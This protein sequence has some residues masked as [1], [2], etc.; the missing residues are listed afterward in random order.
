MVL[1]LL[2][3]SFLVETKWL[4]NNRLGL[5]FNLQNV[6]NGWNKSRDTLKVH[7]IL[8]PNAQPWL[9]SLF[10]ILT[11]IDPMIVGMAGFTFEKD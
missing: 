3:P 10:T 1:V 5:K 8:M 9:H 4:R 2:L 11:E 6:Q 7:D